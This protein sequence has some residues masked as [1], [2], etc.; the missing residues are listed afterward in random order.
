MAK[1]LYT[2]KVEFEYAAFVE[3]KAEASQFA[4]QAMQDDGF[5]IESMCTVTLVKIV[6]MDGKHIPIEPDGWEDD[7][8]VYQT[9]ELNTT[10]AE[11]VAV[12]MVTRGQHNP[13]S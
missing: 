5:G 13:P 1:R 8:L 6:E 3:D 2:V 12:E 11:A 9:G 7:S 10:W 4:A